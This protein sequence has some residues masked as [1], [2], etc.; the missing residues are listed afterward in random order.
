[1]QY[2]AW[3]D[4]GLP[5]STKAFVI[6]SDEV[7]RANEIGGGEL[8][9]IGTYSLFCLSALDWFVVVHCSAGIGRSGTFC[10]VHSV[11]AML[12]NHFTKHSSPPAL[13][14]VSLVLHFRKERPGMVQTKDQFMFCYMAVLEEYTRLM[15]LA[16]AR[17]HEKDE[18]KKLDKGSHKSAKEG[19]SESSNESKGDKGDAHYEQA[20]TSNAATEKTTPA[21]AASPSA[22][23]AEEG[24]APA[25]DADQI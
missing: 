1:M 2:M 15:K 5:V 24:D 18:R 14:L 4:H 3:P 11:L 23:D 22:T 13:N 19:S 21:A 12:R 20:K 7:D 25:P 9:P 17:E 16:R 10:T 8:P 6:L